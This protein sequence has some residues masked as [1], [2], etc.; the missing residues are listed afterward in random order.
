MAD[1]LQFFKYL[2]GQSLVDDIL[3]SEI[4]L[5]NRARHDTRPSAIDLKWR[6]VG[7]VISVHEVESGLDLEC[8]WGWVALRWLT[9]HC[10]HIRHE[11]QRES[12]KDYTSEV[13]VKYD[14]PEV[15]LEV[16]EGQDA[17]E[18]RTEAYTYRVGK[19]PL[20]LGIETLTGQLICIDSLGIQRRPDGAARLSMKLHPEEA[21]YGLGER[22]EGLNLRGKRYKLWNTDPVAYNRGTDPL[23]YNI[24]F[25]IGVHDDVTYG[26]LWDNTFRGVVDVGKANESEI[27]FESEGAPLS[28]FVISGSNVNNIVGRYTE[29][30][31]RIQLPPRWFLGYQQARWSYYPQDQVLQLAQEF[32]KREIPCD[33]IYLDI[34]YMDGFR[35]FT[36]DKKLF[37]D[38]KIMIKQLHAQGFKVI[39]IVDPGIK[40]DPQYAAYQSGLTHDVFLKYPDGSLAAA[41][42]WPGKCHFP[43]FTKVSTQAWWVQQCQQLL[44]TGIDGLWNDMC[45]PAAFASGN[46]AVTLPD[47]VLHDRGGDHRQHHN[48]YGMHMAQATLKALQM[49]S[50]VKRPVNMT[51]AGFAG[52]QRYASSWT[53]DNQSDWD[54]LRLSISM[55]L[56]MG[57]SG[58]PLTGPDVGGFRGNANGELFTRWLQAACLLPYLRSHTALNTQQQEPWSF[59]Q[60]YEAIN[61]VTIEL[62]YRLMPYLYSI[63]AQSAEYGWP[64]VRPLFTAEPDNSDLRSVDDCYMLGDGLLIAPVIEQGHTSR[65]VYLPASSNWYDFWTNEWFEGGQT[66]EVAAPLE[67][68]PLFVRSGLVLP[69]WGEQQFVGQKSIDRLILR[70]YPGNHETI[71]YEDD[72]EGLEYQEGAYR[73]VYITVAEEGEK[74]AVNRRIAGQYLPNYTTINLEVVGLEDEPVEV[75]VD[76]QGAPLWFYDDGILEVT[77]DSFNSVEIVCK[78]RSSDATLM[79]RPW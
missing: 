23:Y 13:V 49:H 33:V 2:G 46:K 59:G 54:H 66:I 20:R 26:L 55:T 69:L 37:P 53:G 34:H 17:L 19:N 48:T 24:P 57:L 43:D 4:E 47:L 25:Y 7:A 38:L 42:V 45:E 64:I 28:Y 3:S 29:L 71:L 31:G 44:A 22:A 70:L 79:S 32:R 5:K 12:L 35:V 51:R 36:W 39:A 41:A 77:T 21:C 18:I 6:I 50:P 74:L 68:L 52:T 16:I 14:W 63:I 73:W 65:D 10:L 30:T 61:R 60:P 62:R 11:S 58:A 1:E 75:R 76:R 56:N 72:G 78:P 9:A 8:E 15:E 27:V 67:R 40:V